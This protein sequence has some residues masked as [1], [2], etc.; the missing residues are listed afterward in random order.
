LLKYTKIPGE[1]SNHYVSFSYHHG[2]IHYQDTNSIKSTQQMSRDHLYV[3]DSS[4]HSLQSF[5]TPKNE[6][7]LEWKKVID[8]IQKQQQA[9]TTDRL[10]EYFNIPIQQYHQEY[11]T[12]L[13]TYHEESLKGLTREETQNMIGRLWEGLYKNYFLGIKKDDQSIINPIGSSEPVIL[14]SKDFSHLYV[15]F[16]TSEGEPIQLILAFERY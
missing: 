16:E 12:N 14:F 8:H 5:R 2:E 6:V 10:I 15:L 4:F 13:A 11:L 9:V 3:I 1:D 7:Q